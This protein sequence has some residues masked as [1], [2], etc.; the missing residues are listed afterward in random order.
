M[1]SHSQHAQVDLLAGMTL[2]Q[3]LNSQPLAGSWG[4]VASQRTISVADL[5]GLGNG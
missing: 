4:D 5:T 3:W 2:I 1:Q